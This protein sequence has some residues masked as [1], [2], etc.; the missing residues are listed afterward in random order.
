MGS[1]I[2]W[3]YHQAIGLR[4]LA[5]IQ[6]EFVNQSDAVLRH[7]KVLLGGN[8]EE[9]LMPGSVN[10]DSLQQVQA[11]VCP[12]SHLAMDHLCD[13]VPC[14]LQ[15]RDISGKPNGENR[16]QQERP[17]APHGREILGRQKGNIWK[18]Y[19]KVVAVESKQLLG[20]RYGYKAGFDQVRGVRLVR[21]RG[22]WPVGVWESVPGRRQR[23]QG[24]LWGSLGCDR[25]GP[26]SRGYARGR[27]RRRCVDRAGD[28]IGQ[29]VQQIVHLCL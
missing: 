15:P 20:E 28:G 10:H 29:Q 23:E 1:C 21:N 2:L 4:T 8:V 18:L 17:A 26:R 11:E 6:A 13:F 9:E 14:P 27:L 16:Q 7:E 22:L 12:V 5:S 24:E 19:H 25:A 3:K